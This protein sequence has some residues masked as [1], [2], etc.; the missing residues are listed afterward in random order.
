MVI[1]LADDGVDAWVIAYREFWGAFAMYEIIEERVEGQR[2]VY[3]GA[4]GAY[5]S[6]W[7][8]K[9]HCCSAYRWSFRE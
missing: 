7:R 6:I 3:D 5:T 2:L 8:Y 1:V 9:R 4:L